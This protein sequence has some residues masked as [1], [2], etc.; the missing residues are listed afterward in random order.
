V[1][2]EVDI[3][4]AFETAVKA[5]NVENFTLHSCRHH[6]ASWFMMN[7][8][9]LLSL[10]RI[11]GHATLAMTT[12]YAHLSP[13]HLRGE[14]TRTERRLEGT[15]LDEKEGDEKIPHPKE[16]GAIP[17]DS[18]DPAH[19]IAAAEMAGKWHKA[20]MKLSGKED[21]PEAQVM[22][23]KGLAVHKEEGL[24]R[25]THAASGKHFGMKQAMAVATKMG[26]H[27]NWTI[28]EA[29]I[30]GKYKDRWVPSWPGPRTPWATWSRVRHLAP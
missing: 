13:D 30:I 14:M 20:T 9:S 8:G 22:T 7:G 12:R 16:Q 25:I 23:R 29:D 1:W 27:L 19:K 2:P 10:N 3:R 4:S 24:W 17:F 6:F 5:A 26:D 15:A 11:L 21:Q 28:P 18:K